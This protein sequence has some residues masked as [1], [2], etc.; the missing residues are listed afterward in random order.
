MKA[1][2][3]LRIAA[4]A[5]ETENDTHYARADVL[6]RRGKPKDA[7][8]ALRAGIRAKPSSTKVEWATRLIAQLQDHLTSGDHLGE[9]LEALRRRAS[10]LEK[11]PLA[12]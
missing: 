2:T 1:E 8:E 11:L 4:A 12:K 5:N 3:L 6:I 9:E 10:A 7:I